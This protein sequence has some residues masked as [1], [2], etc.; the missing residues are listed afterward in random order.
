M[1]SAA[2]EM[3]RLVGEFVP[4]PSTSVAFYGSDARF[5]SRLIFSVMRTAT[6]VCEAKF[7]DGEPIRLLSLRA[8]QTFLK[9]RRSYRV[10]RKVTAYAFRGHVTLKLKVRG[11][12]EE[13]FGAKLHVI[14]VI[15]DHIQIDD[16]EEVRAA[17]ALYAWSLLN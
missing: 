14:K 12:V 11:A 9:S 13:Q 15:Q 16:G 1:C 7:P 3:M 6:D 10:Y 4:F 5:S 8:L 2:Q 17:M